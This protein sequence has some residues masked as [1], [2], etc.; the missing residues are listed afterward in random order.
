MKLLGAE[1]YQ[2]EDVVA[3]AKDLL[4]KV[5]QT[6]IEGKLTS[7]IIVETEAY[8]GPWDKA[9]HAFGGKPTKRTA[10]MFAD[11]GITYV[12]LCYGIH[13]LF[14]IVTNLAGTP[15]AVLIRAGEPLAGI[16]TMLARR[17]FTELEPQLTAG[18]GSMTAALGIDRAHTN[19]SL[20]SGAI[21]IWDNGLAV[22]ETEIEARSR[23]GVAYAGEDALLPWR[24][25]IRGNRWVSKGKGL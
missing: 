5:L 25:S 4:G 11:G 14:N 18:P 19:I 3:I 13:H 21:T 22:P 10:P 15:H 7:V 20:G 16:D 23:V 1:F 9:S 6:E 8:A 12:Y 2:R 24:F 17:K